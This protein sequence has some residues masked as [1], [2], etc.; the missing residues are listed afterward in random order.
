MKPG[1]PHHRRRIPR[2]GSRR[3]ARSPA[4]GRPGARGPL[5][6]LAR[7][8]RRRPLPRPLRRQR[9][10]SPGGSGPRRPLRPGR[11][12]QPPHRED[13]G[14][15]RRT[16]GREAPRNP[17]PRPCPPASPVWQRKEP[18]PSIS[19][20]PIRRTISIRTRIYSRGL[21]PSSPGRRDRRGALLAAGFTDRGGIADAGGCSA[22]WGE[23][24]ELLSAGAG[25]GGS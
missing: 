11:G 5:L 4:H 14:G 10:R 3:A 2:P 17:P 6:D 13:P 7:A 1:R 12:R 19:S 9:R 22:V 23:F 20:T 24:G 18:A 8:H 15:Q 25:V 21:R 16:P